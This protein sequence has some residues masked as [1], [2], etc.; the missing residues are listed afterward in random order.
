MFLAAIPIL[1]PTLNQIMFST[2]FSIA[3]WSAGSFTAVALWFSPVAFRSL[4]WQT[5]KKQ[6]GGKISRIEK[7]KCS[8]IEWNKTAGDSYSSALCGVSA[9]FL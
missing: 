8:S 6:T 3:S 9:T 5:E 1:P 7:D 2:L 4:Y